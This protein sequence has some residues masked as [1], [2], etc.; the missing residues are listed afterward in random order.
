MES[1]HGAT[2]PRPANHTLVLTYLQFSLSFIWCLANLC[3][4]LVHSRWIHPGAN[5]GCDLFLWLL[6]IVTSFFST[7]GFLQDLL[8]S[9]SNYNQ[10]DTYTYGATT[11]AHYPNG[12]S[13]EVTP[14][15]QTPPCPGYNSCA[16]KD[17]VSSARHKRV[18]VVTVATVLAWLLL[19]IHLALFISACRYTHERRKR[20]VFNDKLKS[21]TEKIEENIIRRL[22]AEGRLRTPPPAIAST[23]P[24]TA[25]ASGAV[26]T[27]QPHI[28]GGS[29]SIP[30]PEIR[31]DPASP[32][33]YGV[34]GQPYST[35]HQEVATPA[36]L[37]YP[38]RGQ[39]IEANYRIT[40]A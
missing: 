24:E 17:A 25:T 7:V 3:V 23:A 32:A 5:V 27:D 11:Y 12:T 22:E 13:Y 20:G 28:G 16:E 33:G 21:E 8:W 38:G 26:G 1:D 15:N 35:S 4:L 14:S 40:H 9:D 29:G 19:L 31:V 30:P 6:F 39:D 18:V 10:S 36:P 37:P 34:L 2:S